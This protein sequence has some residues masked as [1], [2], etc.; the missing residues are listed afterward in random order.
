MLDGSSGKV[1]ECEVCHKT[2]F[3]A[4]LFRTK[5]KAG[6]LGW[7][8]RNCGGRSDS[9]DVNTIVQAIEVRNKREGNLG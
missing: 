6:S 4:G 1:P 9:S 3:Q 5:P 8:C 2:V 7:R